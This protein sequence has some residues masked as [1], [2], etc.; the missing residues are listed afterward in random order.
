[1]DAAENHRLWAAREASMPKLDKRLAQ[2]LRCQGYDCVRQLPDGRIIGVHKLLHTTGLFVGLNA[3]GYAYRYCY[4][5]RPQ[6]IAAA[7]AWDGAGH[8]PGPWIKL[9]GHPNGEQL[10]PGAIDQVL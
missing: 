1:M 2:E 9:K 4:E 3:A 5:T 10:G 8:P 6:A 7:N